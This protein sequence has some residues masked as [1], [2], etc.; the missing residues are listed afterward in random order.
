MGRIRI[1]SKTKDNRDTELV[2]ELVK[3]WE[4]SV[5]TSHDFLS[6]QD[7]RN[8]APQVKAALQGVESLVVVYNDNIPAGF[9]GIQ[10]RKIEMLFL[11]PSCIGHGLGREL[12]NMA[13]RTYDAIYVD[14]NEQNKK[15]EAFYLRFRDDLQDEAERGGTREYLHP[16]HDRSRHA[17][18]H[19]QHVYGDE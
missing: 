13:I 10:E 15:A 18:Q 8:L 5:R 1:E 9:M 3:V 17:F 12:L 16:F 11:S 6:E 4:S 7:I 14:V 19:G 2:D